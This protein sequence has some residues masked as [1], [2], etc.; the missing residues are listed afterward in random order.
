MICRKQRFFL[1]I[2]NSNEIDLYLVFDA[3]IVE[4]KYAKLFLRFDRFENKLINYFD[5]SA[6]IGAVPRFFCSELIPKSFQE[7]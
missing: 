4:G 2:T 5:V 6:V 3:Y 1:F 7:L